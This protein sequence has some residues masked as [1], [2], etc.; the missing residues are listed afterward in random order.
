MVRC[1]SITD[2][3]EVEANQR[4]WSSTLWR[5]RAQR[6]LPRCRRRM[7]GDVHCEVGFSSCTVGCGACIHFQSRCSREKKRPSCVFLVRAWT[8]KTTPAAGS[9]ISGALATPRV[10]ASSLR[11]LF[12]STRPHVVAKWFPNCD[13][14]RD[15]ALHQHL[16]SHSM[17]ESLAACSAQQQPPAAPSSAAAG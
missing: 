15:L 7:T 13:L 5:R 9:L 6:Q 2:L 8:G 11:V 12:R 10:A 3:A 16:L 17:Q 14:P 1:E 4:R